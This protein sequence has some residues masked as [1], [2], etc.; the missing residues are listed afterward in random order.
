VAV[1]NVMLIVA[2]PLAPTDPLPITWPELSSFK[3]STVPVIPLPPVTVAV[4]VTLAP[5][6]L[7]FGDEVSV[8]CVGTVPVA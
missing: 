2:T 1:L 5:A 7:G 6:E 3:M 8:I 4:N